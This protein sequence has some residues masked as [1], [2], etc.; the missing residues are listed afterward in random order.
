[1]RAFL[2]VVVAFVTM[3]VTVL[4][5]SLAPWF[6]FG[7]DGVLQPGRFDSTP[8]YTGYALV[9]GVIGGAFAGWLCEAISRSRLAV[10]VLAVLCAGAGLTNHFSQQHKPA[11]GPRPAGVS[12][13][14]AVVQR[15][16]PD[17][18]TLAS[19]VLGV[20]A[21]VIAGRGR[22]SRAW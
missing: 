7:V 21:L 11:P 18:F 13:M 10:Y 20:T 4:A 22:P 15:K 12:V 9:V 19:P 3:S 5:L 16:E 2:G 6:V 17:W 1:M 8:I 14:D